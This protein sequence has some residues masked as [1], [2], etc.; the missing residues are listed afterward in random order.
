VRREDPRR[1]ASTGPSSSGVTDRL[2][3]S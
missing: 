2:V 1:R 3:N